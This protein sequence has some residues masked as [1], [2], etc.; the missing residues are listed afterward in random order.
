MKYAYFT[1]CVA[2]GTCPELHHST[3]EL[4]KVLGIDLWEMTDAT[5]CGAGV[6]RDENPELQIALNARTFAMAEASGMDIVN[7]CSTCQQNLGQDNRAMR[8]DPALL[9]RTNGVL[10]QSGL[11]YSGKTQVKNLLWVL[12]GDY[13][14]DRLKE[15]V[16]RP[17][18]G[19]RVASY[20]GC[21]LLRPV[22]D[23]GYDDPDNPTSFDKL[24]EAL[25]AT[26]VD[27]AG[28]TRCCGF[29]I[30]TVNEDT[31]TKMAVKRLEEAEEAEADIM[32][33]P[34]PL[35]HTSL[36]AY[37]PRATRMQGSSVRMP[38]LHLS[39]LVGLAV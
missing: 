31:S 3:V 24:V 12:V 13:G 15:K 1:G 19:L 39:Q 4:A 10:A 2:K 36:D 37:Q 17:L 6:I 26:P 9:E 30:L 22:E 29:H 5:C 38:V 33:T 34:C 27:Y 25:G 7:I 23:T 18:T 16:V 14:L 28:K 8:E 21:Q 35:C 20:Y 32:V 11:H